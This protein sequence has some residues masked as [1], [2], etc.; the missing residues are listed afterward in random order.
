MS[1]AAGLALPNLGTW[2]HA[3]KD[4]LAAIWADPEFKKQFVAGYG[5]NA[6]I[7][8]RLAPEDIAILEKLQPLMADAPRAEEALKKVLK[9][10]S[11]AR[12]DF[13]LGSLQDQQGKTA[14]AL[15][16][17]EKAVTKFPSFRRA[18]RNLGLIHGAQLLRLGELDVALGGGVSESIRTF[19]IFAS[20]AAEGALAKH[21]DPSKASRPFDKARNGKLHDLTGRE[22][23]VFIPIVILIFAMGLFPRPFLR[24]TEFLWQEGHT[25]HATHEAA[26][27][28][29]ERLGGSLD[30]DA[31][32]IALIEPVETGHVADHA[33]KLR[34][35]DVRVD[36][37]RIARAV[38]DLTAR[39]ARR[40]RAR[41]LE[42]RAGIP[43]AP[44][45]C[46]HRWRPRSC[47]PQGRRA[48]LRPRP[49]TPP[50]CPR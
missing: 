38:E 26:P 8:P 22:L 19:G 21:A 35:I 1:L 27:P 5:V 34:V 24:T 39:A 16:N 31:I 14:L 18:W 20:F 29:Y 3:Q 17:Y 4:E 10:D 32:V 43:A 40:W 36:E 50:D 6:E 33:T 42:N 12:L 7:E 30:L 49:R 37:L 11:S 25:A 13:M 23:G 46:R 2:V 47:A 28:S 44:R 15:A 45:P 41:C 9:P 48:L